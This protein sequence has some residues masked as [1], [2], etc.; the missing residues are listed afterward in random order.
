MAWNPTS[1]LASAGTLYT[2]LAFVY[3][4]TIER[5]E[6]RDM[7]EYLPPVTPAAGG[8]PQQDEPLPDTLVDGRYRV[9]ALLGMGAFGRVYRVFDLHLQRI[10]AVKELLASK[11]TA[12]DALFAQYVERFRREARA[13]GRIHHPNVV[14]VHELHI[15]RVGDYYLVME[16]VDGTNLRDLLREVHTLPP[17]RAFAIALDIARALEAVHEREIVHRDL[18]PANVM[19]TARGSAKLADFGVAW[20]ASEAQL[21]LTQGGHPGTPLYMSPEQRRGY[22]LLDGR[23]DLY[24]LGAILYE[25]L[26]GE[27]YALAKQSAA[28]LRATDAPTSAVV[29]RLLA[30]ETEARYPT[31]EA[32]MADLQR[33]TTPPLP[34]QPD[35]ALDDGRDGSSPPPILP[36]DDHPPSSQ[37]IGR[38]AILVGVGGVVVAGG[39]GG[40]WALG[41]TIGVRATATPVV[42][43]APATATAIS[44][45]PTPLATAAV[46]LAGPI[47]TWT[48]PDNRITVRYPMP[49][50]AETHSDSNEN[51]TLTEATSK[52]PLLRLTGPDK[53]MLDVVIYD[54]TGTIDG[55]AQTLQA[56]AG[57]SGNATIFSPPQDA[58]VGGRPAR[59]L[60]AMYNKD[61]A[62]IAAALWLVDSGGKRFIFPADR[63]GPHRTEIESILGA[64]SFMTGSASGSA[65]SATNTTTSTR[66]PSPTASS[67]PTVAATA[68]PPTPTVAPPG[69]VTWQDLAKRV[70]LSYPNDYHSRADAIF[71][72]VDLELTASDQSV[73]T[74]TL[75]QAT[76]A[77]AQDLLTAYITMRKTSQAAKDGI[78]NF[79]APVTT[80]RI[81]TEPSISVHFTYSE[82]ATNNLVEWMVWFV[83]H[84]DFSLQM[85]SSMLSRKAIPTRVAVT[86]AIVSSVKFLT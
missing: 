58:T 21:T 75:S 6:R 4:T 45:T 38:R 3:I 50:Q 47:K 9:E 80:E 7:A 10:V 73:F 81:A 69:P 59:L 34:R 42:P 33:L 65:V 70:S 71:Q 26:T 83:K 62:T 15:D 51:G 52:N 46:A 67:A 13:A 28:T 48:D 1:V 25:M 18:K 16:Y 85:E 8:D 54:A 82:R 68:R 23:S 20:I 43:T 5:K 76:S 40:V 30:P 74:A 79:D 24:A 61:G 49:W 84:R 56:L 77:T 60:A 29:E 72:V 36:R 14:G 27:K 57:N 31:A 32:A 86:S 39:A 44:A 63:I 53:A 37:R 22:G 78:L 2:I 12:G 19:V 55:D 17:E 41:H 11:S 35:P 66:G 64:V